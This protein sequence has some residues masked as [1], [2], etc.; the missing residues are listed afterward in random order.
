MRRIETLTGKYRLILWRPGTRIPP[1]SVSKVRRDARDHGVGHRMPFA[2][3]SWRERRGARAGSSRTR[4]HCTIARPN[5][6]GRS[7]AERIP[8]QDEWHVVLATVGSSA[9]Y[10]RILVRVRRCSGPYLV[11]C[12]TSFE[13]QPRVH[14]RGGRRRLEN[15]RRRPV[16]G[17]GHRPIVVTGLRGTR[18]HPANPSTVLYG[19]GE[20]HY[21]GAA[22][23]ATACSARSTAGT[24]TE[25]WFE[26]ASWQLHCS[27]RYL[28]GVLHVCGDRGYV[29]SVDDGGTWTAIKPGG[30]AWCNDLVRS[31]QAPLTL[32][33]AFYGNGIYKSID[34]GQSWTELTGGLPASGFQRINLA[35]A[36]SNA[37][38]VYAS[39]INPS[40][41]LAGM[42]KTVNGGN[43]WSLLSSTPNYV[44]TQGVVQ[45]RAGRVSD[46][47]QHGL[48]RR[49]V[50]ILR[51]RHR[52]VHQRRYDVDGTSRSGRTARRCIRISTTSRSDQTVRCGWRAMAAFGKPPRAAR[53]G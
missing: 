20:Q 4:Q 10:Q 3:A 51:W 9:N 14:R 42:Y 28:D 12:R 7:P 25:D 31:A 21:S 29:R 45:Q 22:C 24:W 16:L 37:D 49:R 40:G 52:Q 48:C 36:D 38:V 26:N 30:V 1:S 13:P 33:A 18:D 34:D 19:T 17:A 50:F 46:R 53:P 2:A 32:F 44:C 35:I 8:A 11:D 47:R 6:A 39:F 41:S 15:D 43:S 27:R 23:T 5:H